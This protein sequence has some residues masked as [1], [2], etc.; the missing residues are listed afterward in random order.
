MSEMKEMEMERGRVRTA[1]A[2]GKVVEELVEAI[3]LLG[4]VHLEQ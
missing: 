1:V 2:E 4:L 3:Q